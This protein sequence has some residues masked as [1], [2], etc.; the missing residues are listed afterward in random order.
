MR[1]QVPWRHLPSPEA[2]TPS[3]CNQVEASINQGSHLL[4]TEDVR[5]TG[6]DDGHDGASEELSASGSELDLKG[7]GV[8]SAEDTLQSLSRL[9]LWAD[10]NTVA[11]E[12]SRRCRNAEVNNR[13]HTLVPLKW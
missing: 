6:V 5:V 7:L 3:L 9:L 13:G 10:S 11:F 12:P 4:V 1:H 8:E 2:G